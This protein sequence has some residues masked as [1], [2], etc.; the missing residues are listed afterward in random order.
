MGGGGL[1]GRLSD[2]SW[3]LDVAQAA[4]RRV[5]RTMSTTVCVPAHHGE[6]TPAWPL[7]NNR[8]SYG[9]YTVIAT[10][11]SLFVCLFAS[12]YYLGNNKDRW[13]VNEPPK[14]LLALIMLAIL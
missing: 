12:Y 6:Q 8:G 11:F 7:D 3:S 5:E 10:E 4:E 2:L 1:T 13:A 14:L 9:M